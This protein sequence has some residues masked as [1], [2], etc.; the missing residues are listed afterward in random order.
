MQAEICLV[1]DIAGAPPTVSKYTMQATSLVSQ[2]VKIL[3]ESFLASF[4]MRS[5][6]LAILN[7]AGKVVVIS[8]E[9]TNQFFPFCFTKGAANT[10]PLPC[11]AILKTTL[12]WILGFPFRLPIMLVYILSCET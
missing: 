7:K 3:H 6:D 11:K 8:L 5:Q 1:R 12:G 2:K 4:G 10:P 9:A